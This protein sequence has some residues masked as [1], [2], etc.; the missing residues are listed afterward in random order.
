MTRQHEAQPKAA[1]SDRW[2]FMEMPF[3]QLS[4]SMQVKSL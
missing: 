4:A 2:R 3:L 1:H